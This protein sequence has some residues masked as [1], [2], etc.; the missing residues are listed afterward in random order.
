MSASSVDS[1]AGPVIAVAGRRIDAPDAPPRF[2]LDRERDVADRLRSF[3]AVRHAAGLVAS[4]AC[5]ADLIALEEATALGL[6]RR[7][8]LPFGRDRFRESSVTDRPGDW[9]PRFDRALDSAGPTGI[10]VLDAGDGDAAY[11]ATNDALLD[12]AA[13]LAEAAGAANRKPPVVALLVW[14]G[15]A[16]DG[17]DLTADFAAKA[18]SRGIPVAEIRTTK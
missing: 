13:A 18:R 17:T 7:I 4:A 11:A 14:D 12:E 9:G 6:P 3:L 16:R 2:P 15:T 8:L 10:R 1:A 5:G